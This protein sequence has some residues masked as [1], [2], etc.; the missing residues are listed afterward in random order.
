MHYG[1]MTLQD[2]DQVMALCAGQP[3]VL[4]RD[5]DSPE[6]FARY[7]QRNSGLIPNL[8]DTGP[9]HGGGLALPVRRAARRPAGVSGKSR[10][11]SL[12]AAGGPSHPTEGRHPVPA[13][14]V[15]G[16]FRCQHRGAT[17]AYPAGNGWR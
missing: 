8:V 5:A 2:H 9:F 1:A 3:G 10:P 12:W 6:H 14:V 16:C 17:R 11:K 15:A 4:I 7:L 13:G